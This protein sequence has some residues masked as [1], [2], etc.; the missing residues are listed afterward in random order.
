[1]ATRRSFQNAAIDVVPGA[2]GPANLQS[3]GAAEMSFRK[4]GVDAS[5]GVASPFPPLPASDGLRAV[6]AAR[7]P[8][9]A[10]PRLSVNR[11]DAERDWLAA[12]LWRAFPEAVSENHLS[13]L[14]AQTLTADRRPVTAR[15]VRNWLRRENTPHYRYVLWVIAL[16][17]AERVFEFLEPDSG[18]V[19]HPVSRESRPCQNRRR[20]NGP[21]QN[22]QIDQR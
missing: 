14:A 16:A 13:E 20:Q 11:D 6:A 9:D 19:G 12:L 18:S 5:R 17:G 7:R 15:A 1:M 8:I 3:T 2:D 10:A 4:T 21:N 22:G